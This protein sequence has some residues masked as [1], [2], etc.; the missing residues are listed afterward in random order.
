MTAIALCADDYAQNGGIDDAVCSLLAQRRLTAVSCMSD[1]PRWRD[2]SAPRL[3][4]HGE[5]TDIGLHLNLTEGHGA[6]APSLNTL[7]LR[8]LAGLAP[9]EVARS[10][11]ERQCDAF[12]V[13]LGRAPDFV[14]GHQHVHQLP[15]LRQMVLDLIAGRYGARRPWIRNTVPLAGVSG[16]KSAVLAQLGGSALR[17]SGWPTNA[18]FGG[19]YGFDSPD[20]AR[21]FGHWLDCAQDGALLMCHPATNAGTGDAIGMQRTKEYHFLNS[22]AFSAALAERGIKLERLSRLLPPP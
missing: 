7:I 19:V 9:V 10:L 2:L 16:F 18:G 21:L 11:F 3:R 14:D 20:Y 6:P 1:A 8:C 4:E 17:A 12:E 13:G 15:G 22:A 5:A